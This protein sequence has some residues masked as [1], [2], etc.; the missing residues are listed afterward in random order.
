MK[1]SVCMATYNGEKFIEAQLKSILAQLSR[2]DEVI[3]SDDNSVDNTIM[4]FK[5]SMTA[6]SKFSTIMA[7][8]DIPG[9]L[10]NAL[11]HANG[12]IIFLSDR[13]MSG[14]GG[15]WMP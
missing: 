1:I 6:E 11:K 2:E 9:I 8:G 13:T 14:S 15:K 5:V 4:S 7:K 10:E 3:I 12:D